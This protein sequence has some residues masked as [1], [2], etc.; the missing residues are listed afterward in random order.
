MKVLNSLGIK[1]SKILLHRHAN[2]LSAPPWWRLVDKMRH[3][4]KEIGIYIHS[5]NGSRGISRFLRWHPISKRRIHTEQPTLPQRYLHRQP[6]ATG[7]KSSKWVRRLV[8]SVA[9]TFQSEAAHRPLMT[10]KR[11]SCPSPPLTRCA[12][13]QDLCRATNNAWV[14]CSS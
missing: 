8:A 10:E 3:W 2:E 11:G 5:K 14:S 13:P 12:E 1:R 9:D 4:L 6:V 7:E